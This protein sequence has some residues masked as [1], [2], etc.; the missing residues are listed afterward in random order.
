MSS[1]V[2]LSDPKLYKLVNENSDVNS[3]ETQEKNDRNTTM[4][5]IENDK[6]CHNPLMKFLTGA[7][8]LV[9]IAFLLYITIYRFVLGY[10]FFKNKEYMKTAAT[11]SPELLA[12]SS[13]LL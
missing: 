11:I 8:I 13:I 2:N 10:N 4:V 5:I 3:V 6:Q 7:F 9:L 12:L 1:S